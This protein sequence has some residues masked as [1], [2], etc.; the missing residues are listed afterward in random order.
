MI[1]FDPDDLNNYNVWTAS[2]FLDE[3]N[4]T[5]ARTYDLSSGYISS[6]SSTGNHWGNSSPRQV[7]PIRTFSLLNEQL[8]GV[9]TVWDDLT[10]SCIVAN[11]ESVCDLV[12]DGNG[13]GIVGA[14]DLLGLLTEYGSECIPETAFTC[15]DPVS[16]QGYD[17]QTV[18]IGEQC[19]FAEN[20][21]SDYQDGDVIPSN[22]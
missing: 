20:L 21:R 10:Q 7:L 6:Q 14:G 9:G 16:Y 4:H 15:G 5:R 12:Y 13:N 17:Y 19:W 2:C 22:L 11:N 18:Q 3:G 8:C 1:S